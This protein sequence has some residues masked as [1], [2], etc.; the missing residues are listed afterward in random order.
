VLEIF[1]INCI[2]CNCKYTIKFPVIKDNQVLLIKPAQYIDGYHKIFLP[3]NNYLILSENLIELTASEK[4]LIDNICFP[5]LSCC[6]NS[7]TCSQIIIKDG[8]LQPIKRLYEYYKVN[9]LNIDINTEENSTII[10]NKEF[11][12]ELNVIPSEA[13]IKNIEDYLLFL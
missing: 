12:A 11:R 2:T 6:N 8:I 1:N 4:F 3:N 13:Q 5:I 10:F 9:N 7:I